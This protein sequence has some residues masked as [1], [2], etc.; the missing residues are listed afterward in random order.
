MLG[1]RNQV[2][3]NYGMMAMRIFMNCDFLFLAFRR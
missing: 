2:I 3:G 1:F